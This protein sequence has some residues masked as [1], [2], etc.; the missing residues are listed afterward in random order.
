MRNRSIWLAGIFAGLLCIA[1]AAAGMIFHLKR[2]TG[3]GLPS[4]DRL[5]KTVTIRAAPRNRVGRH[6]ATTCVLAPTARAL[7]SRAGC[8]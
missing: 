7:V 3:M 2:G 8:C 1:A 4:R 5:S 6:L